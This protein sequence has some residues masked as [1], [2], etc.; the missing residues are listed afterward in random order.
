[1][2]IL[3][4]VKMVTLK[5]TREVLLASY[6]C[7]IITD[8]K[9]SLLFEE[10][11]S[12][13]LD[14]PYDNY[15]P[16][17]LESQSEAECRANFRVEKHHIPLLMRL[18]N[19]LRRNRRALYAFKAICL[20]L[21]I[22]RHD[23]YFWTTGSRTLYDKQHRNRLDL[24]ASQPQNHA[25]EPSHFKSTGA[26]KVRGSCF[27][28]RCATKQLV[29][30]RR[31]NRA[32]DYSNWGKPVTTLQ[33]EQTRTWIKVSV[34]GPT[35]RVK[36]TY[37]IQQVSHTASKIKMIFWLASLDFSGR[38]LSQQVAKRCVYTRHCAERISS[39]H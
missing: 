2:T 34:F 22:L 15:P 24:C 32:P 21:S 6:A 26:G 9:I 20:S 35:K 33:R 36:C 3:F 11:S 5:E 30:F 16:F 10:N 12:S 14:F 13:N 17:N 23:T 25:V 7:G 27:Q 28:Q 1:M 39:L 29:W 38:M 37:M 4:L 19:G 8:E 31:W 18:G